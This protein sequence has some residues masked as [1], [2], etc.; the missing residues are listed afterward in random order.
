MIGLLLNIVALIARDLFYLL[1]NHL[2][3]LRLH[4]PVSGAKV[5]RVKSERLQGFSCITEH[6][7]NT[8]MSHTQ[9]HQR[10]SEDQVLSAGLRGIRG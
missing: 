6:E 5:N 9:R 4:L 3:V 10:S 1:L 8:G 7:R 2:F